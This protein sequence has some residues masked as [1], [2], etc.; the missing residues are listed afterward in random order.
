MTVPT[1]N[2][3][4]LVP[5]DSFEAVVSVAAALAPV[6][7]VVIPAELPAL[8]GRSP[9]QPV[10]IGSR[11][12]ARTAV[13]RRVDRDCGIGRYMV[14]PEWGAGGAGRGVSGGK[15]RRRPSHELLRKFL[16]RWCL[17]SQRT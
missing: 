10:A 14:P 16:Y 1:T 3:L 17:R 9:E 6:E 5:T 4:G 8:E 2:D 15:A 7:A 12:A 11:Q 13:K